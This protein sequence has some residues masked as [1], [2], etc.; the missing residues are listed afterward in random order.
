MKTPIKIIAA[1]AT[2]IFL[3]SLFLLTKAKAQT[4]AGG[5]KHS[6]AVCADGSVRAWGYNNYGELGDNTYLGRAV[7]VQ[8]V[9][10]ASGCATNLCNI[11]S[12]SAGNYFSLALKSNGT[13]WA[14]G[15]NDYGQLGDGT[16]I[17]KKTPVQVIG[18]TGI[19]T[20]SAGYNHSV[21]LKSD[22]TVWAWG[23]NGDG[24]L[25]DGTT[26]T[27]GCWCKST[28]V[29]VS[30]LTGIT[31]VSAGT[32]F[33][34]ALKNDGTVWTWG[35]NVSGTLGDGTNTTRTTPVQVVTGASGC[36]TYL[37]NIIAV[38]AGYAHVLA[39]KND[40]TVWSWGDNQSGQLGNGMAPVWTGTCWC[41]NTPVQVVTGASGCAT[42][43]CNITAVSAG[44]LHS[45]AL[46]ND[47]TV[48]A[49][50]DNT[51]GQLGDNTTTQTTTPVQVHGPGNVGFLTGIMALATGWHHSFA[52]KRNGTLFNWGWG[53]AG[54][55]GDNGNATRLTP[56]Q[57]NPLCTVQGLPV[58]LLYFNAT[59]E[60]N[61]LVRCDWST[62]TEINSDYFAVERSQD[63]TTFAQ[64]G[65]V[66]G[67][68]N[69][70]VTRNY[71]FYD[72][73]PYIGISYYRLRQVDYNGAF[74]Y[75]PIR[76]VYI[77]T[78][79]LIIIYPN[80][81]TN[82]TIQYTVAS[83]AGGEVSVKVYDVIG[84]KVI[85]N[86]EMLEGGVVTKKLSTATLSS[87]SYLLQVTNGNL[88]KTQKQ[89][90]IK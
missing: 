57:P 38:D 40:G 81:S 68:G 61:S 70:S 54:Q 72:H 90:V 85:S 48:W 50:G 46:K 6:L 13:V 65:T 45:I 23:Y 59:P 74:T 69:S 84:R 25:G 79:D 16:A 39:V 8:V 67:A 87:G 21:A 1:A 10:G 28:P 14:W 73:E 53:A 82:G 34:V 35:Y 55:L 12:V 24:E 51:N 15:R 77:G 58:E 78:L 64:I 9:T 56:A 52:L 42:N 80:P 43:L 5:Q 75:S 62:A 18:L 83:E 26:T 44:Y 2:L 30:G 7:P 31:A 17:D 11:T 32:Y 47:S 27:T 41:I 89:F 22:G 49:W 20:V 4:F 86:T 29:Q 36:G 60:N 33:S 63:G 19:T 37:C 3:L 76:P 71:I 88:E 66:K